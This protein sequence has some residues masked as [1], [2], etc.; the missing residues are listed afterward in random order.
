[1]KIFTRV[2]HRL[3]PL[4]GRLMSDGEWCSVRWDGSKRPQTLPRHMLVTRIDRSGLAKAARRKWK[5]NAHFR[6]AVRP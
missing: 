4:R 2:Y 5:L 3:H 6:Q 1:M